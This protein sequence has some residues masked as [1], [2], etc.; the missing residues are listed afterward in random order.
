MPEKQSR[1]R[2]RS[3][4]TAALCWTLSLLALAA[5]PARA[6]LI[7]DFEEVGSWSAGASEG[8]SVEIAQDDGRRG[9]AMRL[10][11]DFNDNAGYLIARKTFDLA[12]PDDYAFTFYIRGE[13]EENNLEIKLIDKSGQNVWW[14]SLRHFEFSRDWRKVTIKKRHI[15]FAWGPDSSELRRVAAIE[16]ALAAGRGGEGSVWIDQLAFDERDLG[17]YDL[18][19]ELSASTSGDGSAPVAALD[20]DQATVWHSGAVAEEQWLLIDFMKVREYG[21]LVIDWAGEDFARTY[22]VQISDDARDWRTAFSVTAGNGGRDYVY[23]PE[24]ESR[25]LRLDLKRS[26]RGAGYAVRDIEVKP[27]QF[28]ASPNSFFQAIAGD[29]PRGLYPRYFADEQSYWTVVGV[30]R[31]HQ[32]ALVDE[33]GR[34]EP[35]EG[36]GSIEPFLYLNDELITW[37]DVETSQQL[38]GG[39]LPMPSV[40]WSRPGT[41]LQ[42]SA[43]AAGEPGASSLWLRYRVSNTSAERLQGKLFLA[44]RPFR[45]NPPWQTLG[46]GGGAIRIQDLRYAGG[47]VTMN[48]DKTVVPLSRPEGFG[49]ARFEDD[50][51]T[52]FLVRGR[53]PEPGAVFDSFGYASGALEF[54]FDLAAGQQKDVYLLVPLHEGAAPA[55]PDNLDQEAAA[56][57]WNAAFEA[58]AADWRQTLDRVAIELPGEGRKIAET[59][60]STLGY[61]LIN[62]D[63]AALQ[64]GPR[65]YK[66]TWIRDGALISAALLRLAHPD[67]VRA[68]IEWYAPY[69]FDDGSIPCC[70]DA[71]GA[72]RAVEHDSHGQWIY[73]IGEYYRF[74]RDVGLLTQHWPSIVETVDYINQLR[75][76]RRTAEYEQPAKLMYYGLVPES[77]SHEGY[78]QNPVHSYW[79]GMFTLLGL[80]DAAQIA[81]VLG[82]HDYAAAFATMR[83]EFRS[84]LYASIERSMER[85]GISYIPG[86]AELGDFD[87]TSTAIAVD[88]VGELRSIPQ[89]AFGRTFNEYYRY[90]SARLADRNNEPQFERYTPYEFRI[91][92]PLVR[93]G[94]KKEAHELLQFFL[95]GQRPS[96]W[97]SWAEVVWRNP[98]SP[99]FIG[100]MPHTWVGAEYIRSVRTMF[101]YER[102]G[103]RALVVGAGL[104]PEWVLSEEG[105]SVRRLPTYYG[106][107][108]YTARRGGK[109][110]LVVILS[111]DVN[112]PPGK[113][114]AALAARAAADRGHRQRRRDHEL[115]RAGSGDRS[116][117]GDRCPALSGVPL[118]VRRAGRAAEHR[119]GARRRA[120]P[121]S[122]PRQLTGGAGWR[123]PSRRPGSRARSVSS[124]ARA[125]AT[126]GR[127]CSGSPTAATRCCSPTPAAA[128]R[129]ATAWRSRAGPAIRSRMARAGSTTCATSTPAASGRSAI[130]R[131]A[132]RRS[133]M[134]CASPRRGSTSPGS[135]TASRPP[136]RSR[137][138]RRHRW[139][140]A[141]AGSPTA[142]TGRA[143]SRSRAISRPCCWRLPPTPR[144]PRS[145]SCSSR[146]RRC[147][148][149]GRCWRAGGRAAP[150]SAGS[151]SSAG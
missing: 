132:A 82:E 94:L 79:D 75:Q 11:F 113:H 150:T 20:D 32:R 18:T 98:R 101:A 135:R 123:A 25:Y 86:A 77:I 105:V 67:E 7:D 2:A 112:P 140:C 1:F 17:P 33:S 91:V 147:P 48:G 24:T 89:P 56:R 83:N 29:A 40:T 21:G 47:T 71:R 13:A 19:P 37:D 45:V 114:R 119:L 78:I 108:N 106:T 57:L 69:Q 137:W 52:S 35:G 143:A 65:A 96:A 16:F 142:R 128:A 80:K 31:D 64:P 103:D 120:C 42:I 131:P 88:P 148:G 93:M 6:E 38:E 127:I 129:P 30:K 49:A 66:R 109:S 27:Y 117:P 14:A 99:G 134:P 87:F 151:G 130:S 54:D 58:T 8:V 144:I 43:F 12:L 41:W 118:G 85:H 104:L 53:L 15:E 61:I 139:K 22:D 116:V 73:L 62:A 76:K 46:M 39:Y 4:A 126:A 146:P 9:M 133:A 74:T 60:K 122:R 110:D 149:T 28:A 92:G 107:L 5:L 3:P 72:D 102:E 121:A 145:P 115:Q 125:S 50:S 36:W 138:R 34:V 10:D 44:L 23:L 51:I 90:F 95:A 70:V 26:E 124:V 111:G 97:N 55:L 100:D 141:A 84:D 81:T 136:C 59:L 63:G 68:F